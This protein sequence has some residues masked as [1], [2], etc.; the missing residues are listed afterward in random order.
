MNVRIVRREGNLLEIA[1]EDVD[2]SLMQIAQAELLGDGSVE[3]AAYRRSHPLERKYFLVVRTREGD[4]RE[5]LL[6]ALGRARSR[7]GEIAEALSKGL[8]VQRHVLP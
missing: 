2:L 5:A 7:A 3:F 6:R 4:P 1:V 8:G